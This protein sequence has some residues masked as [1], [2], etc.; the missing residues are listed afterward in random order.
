MDDHVTDSS[1]EVETHSNIT[2]DSD[3]EER[4]L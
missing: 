4:F 3:F 1:L 2:I